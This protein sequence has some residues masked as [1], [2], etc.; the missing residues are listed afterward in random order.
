MNYSDT[1]NALNDS[2][3]T[4][5]REGRISRKELPRYFTEQCCKLEELLTALNFEYG[6]FVAREGTQRKVSQVRSV[7]TDQFE[8][9]AMLLR[10]LG[11]ELGE[12]S[13]QDQKL[14][15]QVTAY[16]R[17]QGWRTRW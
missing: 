14:A 12:N 16:L 15:A 6:E 2:I 8:G 5:K 1:M 4:L 10:D 17:E 9:M 11:H 13:A 7:V 3:P